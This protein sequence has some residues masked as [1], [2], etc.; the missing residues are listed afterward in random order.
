MNIWLKNAVETK[1][2]KDGFWSINIL[3][4]AKAI[5]FSSNNR[6]YLAES[7]RIL[8]SVVF[9]WD[10]ISS[11]NKKTEHWRRACVLF[12]TV[13]IGSSA[14][15]YTINNF[16]IDKVLNPEVY[17]VINLNIIKRFRSP[18]SIA[19]YEHCFRF[20]GLGRTSSVEWRLFRD[21]II[22]VKKGTKTYLAYAEFKRKILKRC[23]AEINSLSDV[24]IQLFEKKNGKT[25]ESIWFS[26]K[27]QKTQENLPALEEKDNLKLVGELIGVGISQNEALS[28]LRKHGEEPVLGALR[29]MEDRAKNPKSAPIEKPS[30][31][32]KRAITSGW[33]KK[34]TDT[35]KNDEQQI[36]KSFQNSS[37]PSIPELYALEQAKRA[38]VIFKELDE[39]QKQAHLDSYNAQDIATRLRVNMKK[40]SILSLKSFYKWLA[41]Q[42]WPAP[43]SAE[44]LLA[45]AQE[46]L[47]KK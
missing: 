8:M 45:F 47:A 23:I 16:V 39:A 20:I 14:F 42:L 13:D 27:H 6:D 22:G 7:A 41:S 1:P 35:T 40:P 30:A 21:I 25:V 32:L 37:D 17:S 18:Y 19:I 31:Y 43:P 44:E 24:E 11:E 15:K 9:E 33:W 38:E 36:K 5:G 29:L 46:L 28:L 26:I 3:E 12:P 4:M 34:L 10:V 2:S